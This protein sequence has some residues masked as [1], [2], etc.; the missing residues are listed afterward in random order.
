MKKCML[1]CFFLIVVPVSTI[2]AEKKI[3][4]PL[5]YKSIQSAINN[6]SAGDTVYVMNN[7]YRENIVMADHILLLGKEPDKTILRGNTKDPVVKAAN[8]ST[9]KNF[10]IERGGIGILSENTNM[11]IQN[12]IIRENRKTGI[13]CLISLPHIQNNIIADNEW[14]GIY[15]ELVAYG[16]R[17]A[18]EHN[19]IT[20]NGYSGITLSRK[21]GVLVQNNVFYRNRQYGIFVSKD[22]KKSRIIYNDFFNNRRNY[23]SN[24]VIDATNIS[25]DPQFPLIQWASFDFLSNYKSPL[26]DLGKNGSPIGIVNEIGLKKLY[27]DSDEDAIADNED[28]CPDIRED[29]DGFE[30]EDGCPEND[31]DK[32]GLFDSKDQCPDDAEDFDGYMDQDGCPDIDNDKDNIPDNRDKCPN[33][34]ETYNGH[35]DED[36]C[37]DNNQ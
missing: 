14:S 3:I 22:S 19:I 30:D 13:Q 12:N 5:D 31:N 27:K 25:R 9:M 18:I 37:P 1:Y 24:A 11:I 28:K 20:D 15:C 34:P 36:G 23:N 7:I 29:F 6:A 33:R 21:S 26:I 8:H 2:V 17:T 35:N 32:D 16:S 10:T 4:V